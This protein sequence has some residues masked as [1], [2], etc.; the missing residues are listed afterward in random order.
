M[1]DASK[2]MQEIFTRRDVLALGGAAAA[3][4]VLGRIRAVGAA[5][6]LRRRPIPRTGELLPIVGL[7]TAIV[8]DIGEDAARRRRKCRPPCAV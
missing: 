1:A 7:G 5:E 4:A 2:S 3:A 8:F 6:P